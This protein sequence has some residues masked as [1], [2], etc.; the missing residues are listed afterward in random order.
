MKIIKN[1]WTNSNKQQKE[2]KVIKSFF[3]YF[4]VLFYY[5]VSSSLKYKLFTSLG[6]FFPSYL[7]YQETVEKFLLFIDKFYKSKVYLVW[8]FFFNNLINNR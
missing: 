8:I 4:F 7:V 3:K 1:I 5:I 2:Y 6:F